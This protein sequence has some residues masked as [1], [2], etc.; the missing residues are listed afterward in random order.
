MINT[1]TIKQFWR[2]YLA[3]LPE[4]HK[5]RHYT[6]PN[7]WSFGNSPQMADE[8]GKLV[9]KS[10]KTATC[11]RYLGENV[12]DDSGLSI[13]VNSKE[14]ILCLIETYEITIRYYKDV[15]AD[16]AKAEG[17]GDL[18]LE[19]WKQVHWNFFSNEAKIEGY[20]LSE[21]MLLNCKKFRVVYINE[22]R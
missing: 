17:E 14:D 21:D 10:I 18:S 2:S 13:I 5:H 7:A 15:D 12:L 8:L 11:S 6:L 22:D 3:T 4:Q 19:Y 20:E 9:L 16:F 1:Q